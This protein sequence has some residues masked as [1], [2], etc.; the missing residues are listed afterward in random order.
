[1]FIFVSEL[2]VGHRICDA[3]VSFCF[4]IAFL[5]TLCLTMSVLYYCYII[6]TPENIIVLL[7][8]DTRNSKGFTDARFAFKKRGVGRVILILVKFVHGWVKPCGQYSC[9]C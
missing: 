6:F 3:N 9:C 4:P 2:S 5:F 8:M 1:L 7:C